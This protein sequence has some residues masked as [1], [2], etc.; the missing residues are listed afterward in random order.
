VRIPCK[1]GLAEIGLKLS[2]FIIKE[3]AIITLIY[4]LLLVIDLLN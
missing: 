3:M 4:S 2:C 1:S